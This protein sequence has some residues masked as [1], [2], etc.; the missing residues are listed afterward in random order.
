MRT[1]RSRTSNG[2]IELRA[3]SSV[4]LPPCRSSVSPACSHSRPGSHRTNVA[5][6][7]QLLS[8]AKSPTSSSPA[9]PPR[10]SKEEWEREV[11]RRSL[12]LA[13]RQED[14]PRSDGQDRA[15]DEADRRDGR[16]GLGVRGKSVE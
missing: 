7:I 16:G 11:A 5:C 15:R 9:A 6:I 12:G 10:E 13:R 3:K 4:R 8:G 1:G 2:R 14:A